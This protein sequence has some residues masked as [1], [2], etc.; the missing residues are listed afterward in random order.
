V[1]LVRSSKVRGCFIPSGISP[2]FN[3]LNYSSKKLVKLAKGGKETMKDKEMPRKPN[4][5][6]PKIFIRDS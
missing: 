2:H 4:V 3:G 6:A 1:V 5:G